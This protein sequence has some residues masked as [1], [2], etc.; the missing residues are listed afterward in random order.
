M[1]A[2]SQETTRIAFIPTLYLHDLSAAIAFYKKAFGATERWRIEHPQGHVHVAEMAV[3][4][5]LFRIH[6]E[7]SRDQQLSPVT[8]KGTTIIM[9]LLA[10]G[11]DALF[12]R[13]IAAGATEISPMQDYDYGYRQGTLRDPFGHHWCLER[14]DDF[15]KVPAMA[16]QSKSE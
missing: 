2:H 4:P 3:P 8:I 1:N 13:A 6:D 5:I 14:F 7:V 16:I 15:H 12:E 10:D 9:G 11:P